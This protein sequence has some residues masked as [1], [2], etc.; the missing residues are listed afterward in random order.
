MS[1]SLSTDGRELLIQAEDNRQTLEL[2]P[3]SHLSADFPKFLSVDYHHW[4]EL[5]NKTVEF[6]PLPYP[7]SSSHRQ[8]L[9]EF[10]HHGATT[11]NNVETRANLIDMHSTCFRLLSQRLSPLESSRYVHITIPTS[12]SSQLPVQVD[13]P[14]MKLSFFLN[15]NRQLES[16]NFRGQIVDSNQSTGTML[17]LQNQLVL[18]AKD[19]VAQSSPGSRSV[20]IPYGNVQFAKKDHHVLV[21]IQPDSD[22]HVSFH[23]Y[24][25]DTDLGYLRSD[26]GLTS[27]LFKIYLHALTSHCLPDPLTRHTGTEQALSELSEPASSSFDQIDM[28]QAKLLELIG[29]LTPRQVY[30]PPHLKRMQTIDWANLP[31]LS[32]HFAFCVAVSNIISRAKTLQLFCSL[33]F[34]LKTAFMSPGDDLLKRFTRRSGIYYPSDQLDFREQILDLDARKDKVC[35]GRDNLTGE[36]RDVGQA[37]AWASRLVVRNWG[38]AAYNPCDLVSLAESWNTLHGVSDNLDLTYSSLWLNLTPSNSW[39]TIYDLCRQANPSDKYA[40]ST[41]LASAAFSQKLSS[42]Q[43]LLMTLVAFATNPAFRS[44]PPPSDSLF[45][46]EDGYLPNFHRVENIVV[47]ATRE[48]DDTPA[49][50]L[51]QGEDESDDEFEHKQCQFFGQNVQ[52]YRSELVRSLTSQWPSTQLMITSEEYES[53]FNMEAC[54]TEVEDY[55]TS[56]ARNIELREHLERLE[57]VLS[58]QPTS[59]NIDFTIPTIFPLAQPTSSL[60]PVDPWSMHR[61]DAFMVSRPCPPQAKVLTSSRHVIPKKLGTVNNTHRLSALFNEFKHDARPLNCR[62]GHE[63][64]ESRV[65]LMRRRPLAPLSELPP[66]GVLVKNGMECQSQLQAAFQQLSSCLSPS[67]PTERVASIAGVWPRIT[68]RTLLRQLSLKSRIRCDI[69]PRWRKGLIA[70]AQLFIEYQRSQRLISLAA[71]GNK[72]EFCKEVDHTTGESNKETPDPDWLLVQVRYTNREHILHAHAFPR[73][74]VTSVP[75]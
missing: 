74:K 28:E 45:D 39:I 38:H 43:S 56:C 50:T 54:L 31:S 34:T 30:Y 7:W 5:K 2:V 55:F 66:N 46:L 61:L 52:R 10:S 58:S 21:T 63:L 42:D 60:V 48:V 73:L 22:R 12:L 14:R 57:R 44:L 49:G 20:L 51:T 68:P 11:L 8:W 75:D 4:A 6:R 9:L 29:S 32:Q 18:C 33:D 69:S 3:H 26:S 16:H 65:D 27:R 25:I 13:L 15:Q 23:R 62:Y 17:G 41:C 40:L 70:Y 67:T 47:D 1:F 53:W 59:K 36:W 35:T 37:A 19:S 71:A 24:L 72:E 64:D